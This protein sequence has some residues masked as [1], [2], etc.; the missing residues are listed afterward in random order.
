MK[1]AKFSERFLEELR[2]L[3]IISVACEKLNISRQSIYR[4][5]EVDEKFKAKVDQACDIGSESICDLA[6]SKLISNVNNGDQRAIEF[7]LIARRKQYY[8]PRKPLPPPE[9]QFV[10]VKT[11]YIEDFDSKKHKTNENNDDSEISY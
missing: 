10:P 9:M 6:E 8:R 4:W 3:P 7:V 1:K 5:M 11:I 2:K